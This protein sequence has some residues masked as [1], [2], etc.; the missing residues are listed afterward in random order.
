MPDHTRDQKKTGLS[1]VSAAG[2]SRSGRR[3]SRSLLERVRSNNEAAWSRLVHLYSPLVY[4]WC[5][6][7]GLRAAVW[8]TSW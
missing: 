7:A 3:T 1:S 4:Y 2:A 6:R 8:K 5:N